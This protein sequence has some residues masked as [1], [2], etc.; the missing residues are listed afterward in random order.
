VAILAER[1]AEGSSGIRPRVAL[2]GAGRTGAL[3]ARS[4]RGA[5]LELAYVAN[6]SPEPAERLAA[7]HGAHA[8][9]LDRLRR[10]DLHVDAI[11]AATSAPGYVLERATLLSLAE[12]TTAGRPL[13]AIDLALPRDVEPLDSPQ[14]E[15]VDLEALRA[16]GEENRQR[17]ARAAAE[18]EALVER[19]LDTLAHRF[20]ERRVAAA[21]ADL[22]DEAADVFERELA[23]LFTGRLGKLG[24]DER[25]AVERWA[26]GAFGRVSHVPISAMK[27]L[28]EDLAEAGPSVREEDAT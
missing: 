7:E 17:R 22:R 21:L 2:V 12:G 3:A 6:R 11:V 20:S 18:A 19:K 15:I 23:Q 16:R 9:T 28:A 4:L 24:G 10:G 27:R 13:L 25:R 8:L 5:G 14:V 1:L 26:R